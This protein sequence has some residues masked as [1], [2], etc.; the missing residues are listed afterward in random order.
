M[1]KEDLESLT[2]KAVKAAVENNWELAK[3]LNLQ[4]LEIDKNNI[5]A[6]ARLGKAFLELKEYSKAKKYFKEVLS[7]DPIN[8]IAR[9]NLDLALEHK[10]PSKHQ[11]TNII[12]EPATSTQI[13]LEI[14]AKGITASKIP[15]GAKLE[16]KILT[17]VA[18]IIFPYKNQ[19]VEL[20]VIKDPKLM[21]KLKMA[22]DLSAQ[23]G[24]TYIKGTDKHIVLL[25]NSSEPVFESERQ[26]FKPYIKKDFYDEET[27]T[28]NLISEE[29]G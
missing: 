13:E 25:I 11:N 27:E 21:K 4:I 14:T 26:D 22:K 5:E 18:K 12:Q 6:K 8:P 17:N 24:V 20:A 3:E 7:A 10:T 28:E 16:I 23:I 9:K 15:T 1:L 29:V 19:K 2:K